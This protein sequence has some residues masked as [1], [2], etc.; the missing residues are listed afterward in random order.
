MIGDDWTI[1]SANVF[2]LDGILRGVVL[3]VL[4]IK[5]RVKLVERFCKWH[6]GQVSILSNDTFT[7]QLHSRFLNDVLFVVVYFFFLFFFLSSEWV[8]GGRERE[9]ARK[10]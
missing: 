4:L 5:V 2:R 1:R 3:L 10:P 9:R 7:Q 6:G 8:W